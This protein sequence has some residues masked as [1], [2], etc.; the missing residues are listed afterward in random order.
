[1]FLFFSDYLYCFD[2]TI[3]VF[4][5]E[6]LMIIFLHGLNIELTMQVQVRA[7]CRVASWR[8]FINNRMSKCELIELKDLS[9]N[10]PIELAAPAPRRA[11]PAHQGQPSHSQ[12]VRLIGDSVSIEAPQC[13]TQDAWDGHDFQPYNL[14]YLTWCDLCGEFIW[15]L[16]KQSLRCNS[17]Y[18]RILSYTVGSVELVSLVAFYYQQ[19]TLGSFQKGFKQFHCCL[20]PLT[21]YISVQWT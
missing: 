18:W 17:E 7:G 9:V 15:G 3:I 13:H 19:Q 2:W 10:D 4:V 21:L 8:V 5:F 1:M 16:Y 11:P 6:N 20:F 14:T 12:V